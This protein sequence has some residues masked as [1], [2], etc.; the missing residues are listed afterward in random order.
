MRG[1]IGWKRSNNGNKI[2][3]VLNAFLGKKD[4]NIGLHYYLIFT[5]K[6]EIGGGFDSFT[7]STGL[8]FLQK[9]YPGI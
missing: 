5:D 3:S 9:I 7:S 2:I 6:Y 8:Q 4:A 1:T